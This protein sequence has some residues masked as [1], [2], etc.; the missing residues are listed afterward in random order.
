[1]IISDKVIRRPRVNRPCAT[2]MHD[3]QGPQRRVYGAA[4]RHDAPYVL[5]FHVNPDDCAETALLRA[6]RQTLQAE[7]Q[8]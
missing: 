5:H 7:N 6:W 1:M 8:Q 3:I 2:C 4:S